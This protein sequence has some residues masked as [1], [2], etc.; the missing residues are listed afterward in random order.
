MIGSSESIAASS[1]PALGEDVPFKIFSH[2]LA[3]RR[4]HRD[5]WTRLSIH[6]GQ[7]T[8]DDVNINGKM[9]HALTS[10][11]TARPADRRGRPTLQEGAEKR[12][13]IVAAA[14]E[15]FLGFGYKDVSVRQVAQRAD[16]STRTVYNMFEGK[17]AL[18]VA[19]LAAISAD[20]EQPVLIERASLR[21]T[22]ETF[23]INMLHTLSRSD[24]L[25][26]AQLVMRDARD[27]PD[28]ALAG[29]NS[30]DQQ[31]V[32]PL[33]SYLHGHIADGAAATDLAKIYISMALAEWNR[34][35]TFLL[36]LPDAQQCARH[37]ARVAQIF[38]KGIEAG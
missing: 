8:P 6:Y 1:C 15:L 10:T 32:E 34:S 12:R 17:A 27:M 23:A 31:F 7:F 3:S 35:V 5:G 18:F 16:V 13:A 25:G 26:F 33:A 14:I 11:E 28:L 30:Q 4:L 20:R 29:H 36:P 24:G 2:P 37:A 19:C 38:A 22:L 21:E 9:E